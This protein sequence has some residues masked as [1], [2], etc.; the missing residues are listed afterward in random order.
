MRVIGVIQARF[1]SRRLPGKILLELRNRPSLDYLVESLRHAALI[2]GIVL[3]TS[4]DPSDDAT[5]A[6]AAE[7]R[8]SC[9]RG[10]LQ[11][12]ALR[13]LRAAEEHRAEAIV[14]VSGDSPLMDPVVV[15]QAVKLFRGGR[16][17][18]ATNV[19][20][21]SFP[22]GQSVEVIAV[23]ALRRAVPQ[24][25]SAEEREHVT[26]HLYAHPDEYSIS[27]FLAA[28]H[29][30]EVNLCIDDAEDLAR[31]TAIL[32]ALP[33][34]PWQVGWRACVSAYDDYVAATRVDSTP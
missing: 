5:A 34:P 6:F 2:D 7:R 28:E 29:R 33:G 24:M 27:S 32:A 1:S 10:P 17:D 16:T 31:C 22:K 30:P 25:A 14:R 8:V 21:R 3:A 4:T 18:V 19:R 20:P 9:H 11:H 26:T 23:R 15:D 12:V 13:L